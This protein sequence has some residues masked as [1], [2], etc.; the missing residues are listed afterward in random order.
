ML[1]AIVC[2]AA[3]TVFSE[4]R[5]GF[6]IPAIS[7]ATGGL[8]QPVRRILPDPCEPFSCCPASLDAEGEAD[9]I[10]LAAPGFTGCLFSDNE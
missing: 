7:F 8:W 3:V 1:L 10:A 2:L 4:N 9:G 6:P 5:F